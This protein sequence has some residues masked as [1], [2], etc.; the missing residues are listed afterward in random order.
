MKKNNIPN[1]L[2]VIRILLVPVFVWLYLKGHELFAIG[3]FITAG[4]T[5]VVDGYIARKYNCISDLGKLLD[6]LADKLLQLSAFLCLYHSN[7]VPLWMPA[8]Y[9]GKELLTALG[10]ALVFGKKKLVVKS[11]VFGKLATVLVFAAVCVIAVFGENMPQSTVNIICMGVCAYF[12]FSCVMYALTE[13]RSILFSKE[14]NKEK[15]A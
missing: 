12:I 6:P 3:V 5:D 4:I 2:S 1:I 10:A 15:T 11:H 13:V 8:A 7:L 9:F 14:E